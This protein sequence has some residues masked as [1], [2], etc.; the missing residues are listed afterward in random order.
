[1]AADRRAPQQ[2]RVVFT[3]LLAL[4]LLSLNGRWDPQLQQVVNAGLHARR[5]RSSQLCSGWD[6]AGADSM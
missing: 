3:R 1:M 6:L 2:H 4:G 5:P